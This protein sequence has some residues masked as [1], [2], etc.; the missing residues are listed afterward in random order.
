RVLVTSTNP[1]GTAAVPSAPSA[2]V[3]SAPPVMTALPVITGTP[4]RT[5]VLAAS[6]GTWAGPD[7]SYTYQWQRS[8]D[9]GATWTNIAGQT[10]TRYTLVAADESTLIR[11]A[12]T[13]TNP[14][15]TAAVSSSPTTSVQPD[16][17]KIALVPTI[18]GSA[19]LSA[20]LTAST[21]TWTP[22][23]STFGYQW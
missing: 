13:A 16:L 15:G 2:V 17:P 4:Q 14:D 18:S 5:S 9:G 12:V 23:D 8:A 10:A 20:V 11:V 7:N 1:D 3:A 21:G 22:S 6:Y 19:R